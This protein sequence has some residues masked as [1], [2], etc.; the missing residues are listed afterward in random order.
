MIRNFKFAKI[1]SNIRSF[2][3]AIS[4]IRHS[5]FVENV[6]EVVGIK[7]PLLVKSN[8]KNQMFYGNISKHLQSN[9]LSYEQSYS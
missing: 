3:N 4:R 5:K 7:K 1:G 2:K 6:K 9:R 8:P